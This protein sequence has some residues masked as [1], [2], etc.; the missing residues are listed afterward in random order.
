MGKITNIV[1]V[2][3]NYDFPYSTIHQLREIVE[4]LKNESNTLITQEFSIVP[5]EGKEIAFDDPSSKKMLIGCER[6]L[7]NKNE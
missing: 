6:I 1:G 3:K 2:K 4:Q 5:V 7:L